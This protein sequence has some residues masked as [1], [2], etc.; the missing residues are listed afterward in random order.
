[1]ASTPITYRKLR[2]ALQDLPDNKL[3]KNVIVNDLFNGQNLF[4]VTLIGD[5][6]DNGQPQQ[7]VLCIDSTRIIE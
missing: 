3:N 5:D 2:D 4:Y 7:I 1:M 6:R